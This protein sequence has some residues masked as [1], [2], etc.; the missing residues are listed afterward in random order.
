MERAEAKRKAKEVKANEKAE[1]KKAAKDKKTAIRY[2][3]MSPEKRAAL[4]AKDKACA[5]KAE[6]AWISESRKVAVFREK[7]VA[8]LETANKKALT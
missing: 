2:A 8:K 3:K 5:L 1:I 4:E 6:A 7:M